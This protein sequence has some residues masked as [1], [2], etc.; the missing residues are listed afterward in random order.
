MNDHYLWCKLL[1][2]RES[3]VEI[4]VFSGEYDG[5]NADFYF[6]KNIDFYVNAL[7]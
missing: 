3:R 4:S 5:N 2:T 1:D 7:E 6:R